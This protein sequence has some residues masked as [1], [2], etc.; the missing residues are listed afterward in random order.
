MRKEYLTCIKSFS[1]ADLAYT[2]GV[3]SMKIGKFK[4]IDNF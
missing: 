2:S 3:K 4:G 1:L